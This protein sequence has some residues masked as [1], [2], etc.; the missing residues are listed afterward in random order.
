M[1]VNVEVIGTGDCQ[2]AAQLTD[3]PGA[4]SSGS[5]KTSLKTFEYKGQVESP[6]HQNA[7]DSFM[8]VP[9]TNGGRQ[10]NHRSTQPLYFTS[11]LSTQ[12]PRL[13]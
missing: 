9:L 4:H 1:L 6:L 12:G 13:K 11:L 3:L 5:P 2:P 8:F 10:A 7:E